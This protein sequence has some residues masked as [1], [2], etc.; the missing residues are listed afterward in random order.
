[1]NSL[2]RFE[3]LARQ[4]RRE[5]IPAMDVADRVVG[6]LQHRV[7]RRSAQLPLWILSAV[8]AAAALVVLAFA[9]DAVALSADPWGDLLGPLTLVLR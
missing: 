6:D 5:S 7:G 2:Q 9:I 4:A 8:S 1:M 3:H